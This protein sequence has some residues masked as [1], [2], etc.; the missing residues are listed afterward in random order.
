MY[1]TTVTVVRPLISFVII[2]ISLLVV[3]FFRMEVRRLGY[4]VFKLTQIEKQELD[5]YRKKQIHLSRLTRS[6]R[7]EEFSTNQLGLSH[8]KP[9]QIIQL[10][11]DGAAIER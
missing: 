6:D 2:I 4:E 5:E 11:A 1:H 10:V 8:A 7:I 3:V 9:G